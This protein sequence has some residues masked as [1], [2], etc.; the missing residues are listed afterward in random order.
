M[1]PSHREGAFSFVHKNHFYVCHGGAVFYTEKK[2]YTQDQL[3]PL[4]RFDFSSGRWSGVSPVC[5]DHE[6]GEKHYWTD[7][8]WASDFGVCCAVLGDC[9]YTF[10]GHWQY[11]YAVHE[12]NLETM[13]WRRLEPRNRK[14]GPMDVADGSYKT[15]MV[16]CGDHTLCVISPKI[17][18]ELHLFHINT[19]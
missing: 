5:A 17:E 10:G 15:G 19:G 14:D 1:E 2:N 9:A 12:L 16:A 18:E 8:T 6:E 11:G 3:L 13:V 4:Q 7:L